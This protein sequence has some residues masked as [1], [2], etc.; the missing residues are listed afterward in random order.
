MLLWEGY[1]STEEGQKPEVWMLDQTSGKLL[2]YTMTFI[3]LSYKKEQY[4]IIFVWFIVA[5]K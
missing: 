5:V 1:G 2:I 4:W 3:S